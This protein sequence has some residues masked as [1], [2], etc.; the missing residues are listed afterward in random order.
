MYITDKWPGK[1]F[2]FKRYF[3]MHFID[4]KHYLTW[5]TSQQ[6]VEFIVECFITFIFQEVFFCVSSCTHFEI[7]EIENI[8]LTLS[9][10]LTNLK[11]FVWSQTGFPDKWTGSS[12]NM[13]VFFFNKIKARSTVINATLNNY[14]K[15]NQG[16]KK[17]SFAAW[18]LGKL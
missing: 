5:L 3:L 14:N 15:Y 11:Q 12:V 9:L 13:A 1:I 6:G 16:A 8:Q 18:P 7:W 17:T 2:L 10:S 4:K